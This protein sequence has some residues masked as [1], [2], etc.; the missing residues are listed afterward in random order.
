MDRVTTLY[1]HLDTWLSLFDTSK[2][3]ISI[4]HAPI[5]TMKYNC[6]INVVYMGRMAFDYQKTTK[7]SHNSVV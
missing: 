1:S 4:K 5:P 3:Y 6:E 2:E 7:F